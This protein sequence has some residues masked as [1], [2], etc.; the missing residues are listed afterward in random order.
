[1]PNILLRCIYKGTSKNQLSKEIVL[2]LGLMRERVS[3]AA[4]RWIL[5]F[6]GAFNRSSQLFLS[7]SLYSEVF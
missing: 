1:M 6:R 4:S 5:I 3:I 7:F 2:K